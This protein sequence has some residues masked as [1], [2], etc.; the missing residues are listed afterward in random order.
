MNLNIFISQWYLTIIVL[1]NVTIHGYISPVVTT[2]R[3]VLV[4][5]IS[6]AGTIKHYTRN[7]Q[8]NKAIECG[9]R[10]CTDTLLLAFVVINLINR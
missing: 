10:L 2:Y 3:T 5:L 1:V 8:A 7:Y 4:S 9:S 6:W